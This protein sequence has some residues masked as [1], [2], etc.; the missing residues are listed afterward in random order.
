MLPRSNLPTSLWRDEALQLP[1][2]I[3]DVYEYTLRALG[4]Y[5]QAKRYEGGFRGHGGVSRED[6]NKH[7]AYLFLNSV[8]RIQCVMLDPQMSFAEISRDLLVTFS[9]HR[10]SLLDIPCG[11]GAGAI[12]TLL[13]LKELRIAGIL[14]TTPLTV[15][16]L[17]ADISEHALGLYRDQLKDLEPKLA[18]V[19]I[20][21]SL[22]KLQWDATNVQQTNDLIDHYLQM[23]AYANEYF[24]LVANFKNHLNIF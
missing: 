16:I 20:S 13:T 22:E 24:V 11:S 17:G 14:P 18:D 7:Y 19:G 15:K 4:L 1:N 21:I 9:S 3:H 10:I 12:S 2:D 6:T 8:S 5:D 23:D